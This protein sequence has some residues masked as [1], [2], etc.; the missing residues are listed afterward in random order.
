[1][2]D[3]KLERTSV[4]IT[5]R[6]DDGYKAEVGYKS[7]KGVR[8]FEG[9]PTRPEAALLAGVEELARLTALFGFEA[10][11]RQAFD[12]ATA[13]VNEWRAQRAA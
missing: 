5:Y 10:E 13:R 8:A 12:A 6:A 9:G 7:G 11:A 2:S 1:M 3:P 4:Q